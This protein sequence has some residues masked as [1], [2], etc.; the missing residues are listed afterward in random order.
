[1]GL[2]ADL[3]R[4]LHRDDVIDPLVQ[5]AIAHYQFEAI[6]PFSDGNGRVGRIM[7]PLFL[8]SRGVTTY[9]NIYVSEYLEGERRLYYDLLGLVSEEAKWIEWIRFFLEAVYQQTEATRKKVGEIELLYAKLRDQMRTMGS[10]YAHQMLDA[11]FI[12]PIFSASTIKNLAK[13]ENSQTLYTTIK[14]FIDAGIIEDVTPSRE[15][16]KIYAFRGLSDII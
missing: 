12:Q 6:H 13:I 2:F 16:K 1:M 5:I 14:K 9:P 8:Y 3:E 7:I 4:Y 10:I 15:R 11:L